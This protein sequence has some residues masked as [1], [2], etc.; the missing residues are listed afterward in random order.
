MASGQRIKR[1]N[2]KEFGDILTKGEDGAGA[3][4][5]D[6]GAS[7]ELWHPAEHRLLQE[8]NLGHRMPLPC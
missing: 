1:K 6:K 5:V 7:R 8:G 2:L 4:V 3:E